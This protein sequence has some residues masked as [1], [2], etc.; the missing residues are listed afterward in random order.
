[1]PCRGFPTSRSREGFEDVGPDSHGDPEEYFKKKSIVLLVPYAAMNMPGGASVNT[2]HTPE[3][4]WREISQE[5]GEK[6]PVLEP[7]SSGKP[8]RPVVVTLNSEKAGSWEKK[9]KMS[10]LLERASTRISQERKGT[11]LTFGLNL[12]KSKSVFDWRVCLLKNERGD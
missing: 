10:R 3:A 6:C 11:G 5:K 9:G 7:E 4:A 2:L 1:M 8:P 12:P